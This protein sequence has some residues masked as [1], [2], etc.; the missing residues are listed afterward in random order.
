MKTKARL[1]T[2]R[3]TLKQKLK[4]HVRRLQRAA[5]FLRAELLEY[6]KEIDLLTRERDTARRQF[7]E[8]RTVNLHNAGAHRATEVAML[9]QNHALQAAETALA[10]RTVHPEL[11]AAAKEVPAFAIPA[12]IPV[13]QPNEK[14]T[15]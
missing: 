3:R 8:T 1:R 9:R 13:Q 10:G 2:A 7:A 5:A 4:A 14:L 12:F 6:R 11:A 15:T